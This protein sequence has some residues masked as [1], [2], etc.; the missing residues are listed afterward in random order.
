MPEI[1]KTGNCPSC[2]KHFDTPFCPNCG[3][4]RLTQKD[5]S[6]Y[7]IVRD[8]FSDFFETDNKL[9]RTLKAFVLNP[10]SYVK[11]YIHGARKKYISPIK[12]FLLAN[13]FY[14]IFPFFNTFTTT[15][16]IQLNYLPYSGVIDSFIQK[17]ITSS[18]RS[19]SEYEAIYNSTTAL[20]S[21][22]LLILLPVF[23]AGITY[24]LQLKNRKE[25]ALIHHLNH[26]LV[27]NTFYI[28]FGISIIPMIY[29]GAAFFLDIEWMKNMIT[30]TFVNVY[31]MVLLNIYGFF[32]YRRFLKSRWYFA[33]AQIAL[34]NVLFIPI[35]QFYRF[36][37]LWVTVFWIELFG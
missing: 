37:L 23:L 1:T 21:K 27:L 6:V 17:I 15:L 25:K 22:A 2:G 34:L 28:L 13:A 29:G 20:I 11:E 36:I 26:S 30:E 3:E 8:F 4:R 19:F 33:I 32:L 7:S 14:F 18:G 5:Y 9:L 16:E 31:M 10:D 35:L 12:L 24:L